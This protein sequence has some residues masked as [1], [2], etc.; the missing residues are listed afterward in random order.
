MPNRR[1]PQG[2]KAEGGGEQGSDPLDGIDLLIFD[3]DGTLIE[4]HLMW[5]AWVEALSAGL[6]DAT[7]LP[8]RDGLYPLLGVEP[9]TGLV[10][11][12]GMLAA[13]PMSRIREA[14]GAYVDSAGAGP[15]VATAAVAAAWHAPDPV[16]LAQPVTDLPALLRRLRQR[17][18]TFAVAT[19]DDRRPTERTLAALGVA[20]EFAALVCADDGIRTKPAPDPVVHLCAT[21]GIAPERAAVVGDSPADLLMGRSAGA[22]RVIGVLTGVGDRASLEPLADLVLG[23]IAELA[24]G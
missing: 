23:S 6:E 18:G 1:A 10:H 9:A 20:G 3:K 4:F 12:H 8:L 11:A 17:V 21:L 14:I 7:G 19:S 24:P 5:G 13:T 15:A 22:A 2:S 16:A